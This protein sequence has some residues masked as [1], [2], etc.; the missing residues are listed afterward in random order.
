MADPQLHGPS[1][2]AEQLSLPPLDDAFVRSS[3]RGRRPNT[4]WRVCLLAWMR[5]WVGEFHK[6][7][8]VDD[9][10]AG[11]KVGLVLPW[12]LFAAWT[13]IGF[14]LYSEMDSDTDCAKMTLSWS[15]IETIELLLPTGCLWLI[16]EGLCG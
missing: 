9:A 11:L 5:M 3:K 6:H 7:N 15:I 1:D 12:L 13:V 16:I 2:E 4:H 14:V 8:G 10:L